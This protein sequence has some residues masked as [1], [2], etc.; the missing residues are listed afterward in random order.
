MNLKLVN[1]IYTVTLLKC[2]YHFIFV[3]YFILL[4][5]TDSLP[6]TPKNEFQSDS[7]TDRLHYFLA[8]LNV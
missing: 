8:R 1:R 2:P 6:L 5:V 3:E 7:F 4:W